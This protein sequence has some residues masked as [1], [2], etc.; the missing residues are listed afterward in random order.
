MIVSLKNAEVEWKNLTSNKSVKINPLNVK[1][2]CTHTR[3][4]FIPIYCPF[5]QFTNIN[6]IV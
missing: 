3:S 1:G 5:I 4:Q 2:F 6:D